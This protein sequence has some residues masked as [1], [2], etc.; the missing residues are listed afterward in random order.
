MIRMLKGDKVLK[1]LL[2]HKE[3]EKEASSVKVSEECSAAI[4]RNLPKKEGDPR[5]F[6]LSCLIRPLSMK[7]TLA[8]LGASI[9]LM[10]LS[11]FLQLGMLKPSI[12]EPPKLELKELPDHLEYAF[13]Q[14]DDQLPVVISSSLFS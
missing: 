14:E 8:D 3:F 7:N 5:S 10:P 9:N 11:L 2:S 4:Q 13:L 6:T 12:K 1:D